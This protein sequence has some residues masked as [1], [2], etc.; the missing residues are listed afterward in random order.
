MATTTTTLFY[1]TGLKYQNIAIQS[2]TY[3]VKFAGTALPEN[4]FRYSNAGG[5]IARYSIKNG[6]V[7]TTESD[8]FKEWWWGP[9]NG[10][11]KEG[12]PPPPSK[13]ARV[14]LLGIV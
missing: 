7:E 6:D 5:L 9:E 11:I 4:G 1:G 12:V 13:L 3:P 10:F 14:S 2:A 8:V